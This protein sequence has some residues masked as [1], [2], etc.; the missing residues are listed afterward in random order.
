MRGSLLM[1][2]EDRR[3][4]IMRAYQSVFDMILIQM[5]NLS[6]ACHV[7]SIKIHEKSCA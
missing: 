4:K 3:K 5:I 6:H 1:E 2:G 7:H